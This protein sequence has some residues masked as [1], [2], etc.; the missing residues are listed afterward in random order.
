MTALGLI[1]CDGCSDGAGPGRT[2]GSGGIT[3]SA[4]GASTGG[5][6]NTTG[7]A[8]EPGGAGGEGTT[9][10]GLGG[11][12]ATGGATTGGSAATGGASTGGVSSGRTDGGGEETG[13]APGTG[14]VFGALDPAKPPRP[15]ALTGDLGT[16]D[17]VVIAAGGTYF[18][19]QTG[20]GIPTKRSTNLVEWRR[21]PGVFAAN[22][23]WIAQRVPGATDLW[24]PDIS[25]FGGV[26]HLYYSASTFG[27]NRSCIG[28][29]TAASLEPGAFVDQGPIVCSNYGGA[30]D[31]WNAIDP[32]VVI[33][34]AGTPW[35]SFGS[36]WSGLKLVRLN[37][38]GVRADEVL[39][40]IAGRPGGAGIEAPFIVRRG[41]HYYLFASFDACCRGV[42]STYNVR[43]GRAAD[44]RG[45]YVDRA[46]TA[47]TAGGGTP[48]LQGNTRYR[49]PGHNAVLVDG[50]RAYDIHHAYDAEANGAAVLRISELVWDADGWPV[51]GGP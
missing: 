43:V 42:D 4:G 34:A 33:D 24:A 35:L 51:S 36:F 15:L 20:R 10:G 49:G 50:A 46:G 28:H 27:S 9:T 22:P 1:F 12:A 38:A 18:L 5:G 29:A 3:L 7:G 47:M 40:S 45:P 14:G 39:L 2:G 23:A 30:R 16:H 6:T 32:N 37:S 8:S 26:F 11:G 44:V 19:F 48:L 41:A 21:G 31:D 17:P 13:G 25:H